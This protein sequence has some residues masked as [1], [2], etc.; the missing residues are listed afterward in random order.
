MV[1]VSRNEQGGPLVYP[2]EVLVRGISRGCGR[3][4][5]YDGRIQRD[6]WVIWHPLALQRIIKSIYSHAG[7]LQP[8]ELAS[9]R[10]NPPTYKHSRTDRGAT[11][12]QQ[13]NK[14]NNSTRRCMEDVRGRMRNNSSASFRLV[15]LHSMCLPAY[16]RQL[17]S[18]PTARLE[19]MGVLRA[20]FVRGYVRWCRA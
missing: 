10:C 18:R 4:H 7:A 3:C 1:S 20:Y 13:H 19:L 15:L 11:V 14:R 9:S 6:L 16:T 5:G 2:V 17:R 12:N 8:M